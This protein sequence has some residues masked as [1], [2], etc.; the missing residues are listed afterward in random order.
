MDALIPSWFYGCPVLGY[1]G[2]RFDPE[3]VCQLLEKY[4][5]R[6]AF[7]PPT[8]LKLLRQLGS[9]DR[10]D[11]RLRSIMSAGETVGSQLYHWNCDKC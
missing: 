2:G 4:R 11:L 1:D 10:F 9:L 8:A 6:N 3:R 7:I 5:V